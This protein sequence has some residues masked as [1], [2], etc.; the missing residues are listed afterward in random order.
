MIH[1]YGQDRAAWHAPQEADQTEHITGTNLNLRGTVR[2][3]DD[4]PRRTSTHWHGTDRFKYD[5]PRKIKKHWYATD[6]FDHDL[7]Q[8]IDESERRK[9]T[10]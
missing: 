9:G 8:E 6:C 4:L 7:P 3:R 10:N 2:F 5:L 1:W